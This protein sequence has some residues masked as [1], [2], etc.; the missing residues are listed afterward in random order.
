MAVFDEARQPLWEHQLHRGA[1]L[2][3]GKK[4]CLGNQLSSKGP[5]RPALYEFDGLSFSVRLNVRNCLCDA[6][7]YLRRRSRSPR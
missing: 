3:A 1:W 2:D 6:G 7:S 4:C 5:L